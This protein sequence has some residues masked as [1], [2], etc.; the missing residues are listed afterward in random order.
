MAIQGI[1]K[2]RNPQKYRG[3]PGNIIYRSSWECR[4]MSHLDLHQN[5]IWWSSEEIIIPYRSPKD[6]RLHRYYPDFVIQVKTKE[7][8]K[9]ILMIE[10]K[11]RYETLEPTREG[12]TEKKFIREV[13]TYGINQAKWK[14][15]KDYCADRGWEFCIFTEK[16]LGFKF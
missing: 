11:P 4:L 13:F 5:V 6:G 9:K 7:N 12:K 1:F 3:N 15:A 8:A 10:V 14:A 16:E 2:P